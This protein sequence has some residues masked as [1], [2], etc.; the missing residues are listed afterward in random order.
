MEEKKIKK[1]ER[2]P[3]RGKRRVLLICSIALVVI[4]VTG[5]GIWKLTGGSNAGNPENVLY[6]DSVGMLT[7]TG[8]GTQNRFAGVVESQDTLK[9]SLTEGQTVKEIFVE[10]GQ[11]VEPGTPLFQYDTEELAMTLEQGQLELERINKVY[12]PGY[13]KATITLSYHRKTPPSQKKLYDALLGKY[14]TILH[15]GKETSVVDFNYYIHQMDYAILA[16]DKV[17][18]LTLHIYSLDNKLRLRPYCQSY[19]AKRLGQEI[20]QNALTGNGCFAGTGL[21]ANVEHMNR[22]AYSKQ[23]STDSVAVRKPTVEPLDEKY[24]I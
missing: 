15:G 11:E 17:I 12:Q 3:L 18:Q 6:A 22:L 19:V 1:T 4:V 23:G 21:K 20:L 7:G 8:L 13:L 9:I 14:V 16:I 10:Q 24:Y 5:V 2:E